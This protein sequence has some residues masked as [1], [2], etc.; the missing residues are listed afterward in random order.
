[1]LFALLGTSPLALVDGE[2]LTG[3][4]DRAGF[5]TDAGT[6]LTKLLRLEESGHV[7]IQRTPSYGF[8]L[9]ERGMTAAHDLG[10]GGRVDVVVL[11]LDLVGFVAFTDEHGDDA[12]RHAATALARRRRRRAARPAAAAS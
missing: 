5:R 10:P 2:D 12:A 7:A 4:L 11:M 8:G 9:T 1:M 6:L 3:R